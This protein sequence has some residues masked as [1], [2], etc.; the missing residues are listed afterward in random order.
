M[1]KAILNVDTLYISQGMNG[2]Y[3]HNG[4]LA[5]DICNLKSFKAPFTGVI[6]KIY[7]NV[8]G[9]WLESKDKVEYA[10]G[11]IDYMTIMTLHDN[12][13]SNLKV[14]QTIKQGEEYYHPGTKGKVTGSHIHLG[15]G[16]GKYTGNG[17]FKGEYQPKI[18]SY[19]WPINNQYDITK[20]LYLSNDVIITKKLYNWTLIGNKTSTSAT[21]TIDEIANDVIKGLWGNGSNRKN[22]LTSAGY[23]YQ[24]VQNKVN[25]ILHN[26]STNYSDDNKTTYIVQKGDYLIKIGKMFNVNW[27]D[28][29]KDNNIK[30]PYIIKVGQKLVI[31]K[32]N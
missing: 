9:V 11:T 7:S 27:K 14:G 2:S 32:N 5:I 4:E 24:A 10:D 30:P 28:I 31:N 29:A 1:E 23:D 12:D 16:R 6:K 8:N 20:A 19:A 26:K 3:S 25:E 22:K 15:V 17:W 21:R 18:K 13:I